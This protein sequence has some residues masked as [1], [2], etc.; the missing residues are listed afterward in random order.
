MLYFFV[1]KTFRLIPSLLF[2]P[3][4]LAGEIRLADFS[5]AEPRWDARHS[6]SNAAVTAEGLVFSVSDTDPWLVGPQTEFPAAPADT[7][8]VRFTLTCEPTDSRASWQ[9][10]YA[11]GARGFSEPDSCRL[12]P[13]GRPPYTRF[14]AEVPVAEVRE[15]SVR[16]RIDPPDFRRTW[17]VKTFACEFIRPVW[18]LVPKTP[19]PLELPSATAPVLT[20]KGWRLRHDPDLIGAFSFDSRA[21]TVE[22]NPAEPFVY[23]DRAGAVR[24]LD[25]SRAKMTVKTRRDTE[26]ETAA[27]L[28]DADGR[29][30]RLTRWFMPQAH[31]EAL[32]ISTQIACL[33]AEDPVPVLHVPFLTLFVDR[34][35]NGSKHQ[36][37]L[38]G[39]EYLEDEPSSNEKEIRTG[40]HNRLIP[41]AHRLSAPLAVFTDRR[42]WLAA[43]WNQLNIGIEGSPRAPGPK[44]FATVFDTPDRLF[45]SGGHLL[46]FWAPAV[47]PARRE[48]ELDIY[49]PTP[50]KWATQ[51]VTLRTGEGA[52]V[53]E[54]L[55]GVLPSAAETLPTPDPID[56]TA[57]LELLARGWLDSAIRDGE[58][59]RHAV[60]FAWE[61]PSDAPVLMRYLASELNR[62]AADRE[63]ASR[64]GK[65]AADLLAKIPAPEVGR[66][67]VS[68]IKLPAP[69]LVAGDP[70][71]E[72]AFRRS[73]TRELNLTLADGR[74]RWQPQPGRP[75]FGETLGADHCNGYTAM[76][77]DELLRAAVWCGDEEEISKTLAIVDKVTGLYHGTV[78]R[79]AQPWEMPL[80]T[81][82]IMASAHLTRIY[83]LANLLRPSPAYVSEARHWAYTGLSMVYLVPPPFDFGRDVDPVGRYATC[84]VMGATNWTQPNWIGRPVQ[85]CGLV[86]ASALWN[87]ARVDTAGTAFW[88]R[89]ATGITAS[90]MRQTHPADDQTA[91]GLLPDSWDLENQ[92]RYPVPINPGTVQENLA[93]AIGRPYYSLVRLADGSLLHFPGAADEAATDST[94]CHV[95]GWPETAFHAVVTRVRA[96]MTAT[97]NGETVE[98]RYDAGFHALILTLPAGASGTLRLIPLT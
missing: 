85:W 53:A 27:E 48:S 74:R 44:P 52:S 61:R 29:R 25:W 73:R 1:M 26:L 88:R 84:A 47:G 78:P 96:P 14:Q 81:P 30:W 62:R 67:T 50:F 12:K 15:G 92:S 83:A 3:V 60:P 64:L 23:L 46:A 11:F 57:A 58:R 35:S 98:T 86:Y 77:L 49:A 6:I 54:A 20:G 97:L 80:H 28:R 89:L 68:H 93:E 87:L 10:F 59:V 37:M 82:D 16:F 45:A 36:A 4:A 5:S 8:R 40:E 75:D 9:L 19:P 76:A 71:A 34:A 56:E 39:V 51:V 32:T 38:A 13:V 7:R 17:T 24:T 22:N 69:A 65:T 70:L 90:G 33:D 43:T 79:G 42:S 18:T 66:R 72:L 41:A 31:G 21:K 63:L 2:V 91:V 95:E 55:E 94:L